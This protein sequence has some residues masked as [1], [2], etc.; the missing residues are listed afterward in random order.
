MMTRSRSE[1]QLE[2]GL[3][4][5]NQ[6]NTPPESGEVGYFRWAQSEAQ[7]PEGA[8]GSSAVT[9]TRA[10]WMLVRSGDVT[11]QQFVCPS[12][13]DDSADGTENVTLYYDFESYSKISYGYQVPFGPEETQP[14]EGADPRRIHAADK[15]PFYFAAII[16]WETGPNGTLVTLNNS[17]HYWRS[18]NSWNHGGIRQGEGQNV[19]FADGSVSFARIPAVGADD[20]NIYTVMNEDWNLPQGFNRIHGD[21]PHLAPNPYPYPGQEV[22]SAGPNGFSSTDTLMYP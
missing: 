11:V 15:G 19:L 3:T 17:P 8:G 1:F 9:V 20:D 5:E 22:I 13:F 6:H 12:A 18:F 21:S 16:S 7:S 14:R 10:F 4:H 2:K